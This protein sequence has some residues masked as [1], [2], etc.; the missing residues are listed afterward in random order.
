MERRPTSQ[1]N[2]LFRSG[3]LVVAAVV[4]AAAAA[5]VQLRLEV[6]PAEVGGN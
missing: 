3:L 5:A 4:A 2:K 6:Q 1:G